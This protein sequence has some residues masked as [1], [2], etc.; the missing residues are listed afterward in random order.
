MDN[1][2]FD[3]VNKLCS[4]KVKSYEDATRIL[5][6]FENQGAYIRAAFLTPNHQL[7]SKISIRFYYEGLPFYKYLK[8]Y[9]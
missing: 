1:P 5:L 3:Q 9:Y 2:E 6:Q 4:F 7:G 8:G